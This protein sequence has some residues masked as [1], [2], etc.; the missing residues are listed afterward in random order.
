VTAEGDVAFRFSAS[1]TISTK[2][3]PA[4]SLRGLGLST[5]DG[6]RVARLI[7]ALLEA[8]RI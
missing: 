6:E 5:P 2:V 4:Q 7:A 3:E 8:R 1:S